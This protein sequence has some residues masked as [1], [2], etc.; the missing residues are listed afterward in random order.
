[1][2]KTKSH[3]NI[4]IVVFTS[5]VCKI[6]GL[7]KQLVIAAYF[8]TSGSI[9]TFL[10]ANGA[11]TDLGTAVFSSFTLVY[12]NQLIKMRDNEEEYKKYNSKVLLY[13]SII[14][15]CLTSFICLFSSNIIKWI[16]P[17]LSN[18]MCEKGSRYLLLLSP[19]LILICFRAI[20]TTILDS[21][22]CFFYGRSLGLIQS[23][24]IILTIVFY[25]H[26]IGVDVLLYGTIVSILIEVFIGI[27]FLLKKKEFKFG[28]LSLKFDKNL[29]YLFLS[30]LPLFISNTI[31]EINALI[32]RAIAS[33]LGEGYISAISYS[34][35]LKQFVFSVLI[36]SVA[37]VMY[38]DFS[39][40]VSQ[41]QR[42]GLSK[43]IYNYIA[44]FMIVII[45]VSVVSIICSKD[46]VTLVFKR[47]EFDDYSVQLSSLALIGYGLGFV[48][49]A[50]QT[51][52]LRAYYSVGNTKFPLVAT[53]IGIIIGIVVKL[54][55]TPFV[56]IL[57]ISL[58][59][60]ITYLATSIMLAFGL[61]KKVC[62]F[63]WKKTGLFLLKM[64]ITILIIFPIAFFVNAYLE[65]SYV[66]K[67]F[68][69]TLMV[70]VLFALCLFLFNK[71]EAS[72]AIQV[73][74]N[75]FKKEQQNGIES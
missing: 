62:S 66:S 45:P 54:I 43:R 75:R 56:G 30:M 34:Q 1:M 44:L 68:I 8:G 40:D 32:D 11:I 55:I 10:L 59:T 47:G 15:L 73:I 57:G 2:N 31:A 26:I 39:I 4:I 61:K 25:N 9:D 20:T 49:F 41:Q 24:T 28:N 58:S 60:S 37:S 50:F 63:D 13:F 18:E 7:V 3:K 38:T 6:A 72:I 19:L 70:F 52:F 53:M 27:A 36:T 64:T 16:G 22:K 71:K 23:V 33:N 51:V 69:V 74:K 12:L 17:G 48:F 42:D 46:I 35:T 14:S 65:I 67:F 29:K 5:I 21:K